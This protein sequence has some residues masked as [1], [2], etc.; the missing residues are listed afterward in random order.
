MIKKEENILFSSQT[1]RMIILHLSKKGI[2]YS[3]HVGKELNSC[4]TITSRMSR[5]LVTYGILE[6]VKDKGKKEYPHVTMNKRNKYYRLTE[7][8]KR[9]ANLIIQ[10]N[11]EVKQ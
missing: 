6:Y 11:E 2:D 9:I 8:G 5:L 10:L 1:A 3:Q 4:W 7:K